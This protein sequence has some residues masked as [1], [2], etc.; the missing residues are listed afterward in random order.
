MHEYWIIQKCALHQRNRGYSSYLSRGP[1]GTGVRAP[2]ARR[3]RRAHAS[4]R[5][6]RWARRTGRGCA[7]RSMPALSPSSTSASGNK[8][9]VKTGQAM[10]LKQYF[11]AR[12]HNNK[13]L[14]NFNL[15]VTWTS[16]PSFITSRWRPGGG[17]PALKHKKHNRKRDNKP[18]YVCLIPRW[19]FKR[20]WSRIQ[21]SHISAAW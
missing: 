5:S 21:R 18:K 7:R 11:I 17:I 2:S 12:K 4:T 14:N 19:N 8:S 6:V 1:R 10:R 13:E 16:L 15:F 20:S 3:V 9:K